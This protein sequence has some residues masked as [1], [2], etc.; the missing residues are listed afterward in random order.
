MGVYLNITTEDSNTKDSGSLASEAQDGK[1]TEVSVEGEVTSRA[2]H[3]GCGFT[4]FSD[5]GLG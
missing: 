4:Q 5:R 1:G 2:H 3:G